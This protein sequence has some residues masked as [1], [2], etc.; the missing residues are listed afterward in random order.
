MNGVRHTLRLTFRISSPASSTLCVALL[1]PSL[2]CPFLHPLSPPAP[3]LSIPACL[4]P[5]LCPLCACPGNST[6]SPL[7]QHSQGLHRPQPQ[8]W[9]RSTPGTPLPSPSP[10]P[11]TLLLSGACPPQQRPLGA[12]WHQPAGPV[13]QGSHR[14]MQ[15]P[16]P[17]GT[18]SGIGASV[19]CPMLPQVYPAPPSRG[20]LPVRP[21]PGTSGEA[22][23]CTRGPRQRRCPGPG[24]CARWLH[25]RSSHAAPRP[26]PAEREKK[27]KRK[28]NRKVGSGDPLIVAWQRAHLAPL[29]WISHQNTSCEASMDPIVL[30]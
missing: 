11:S 27:K 22:P 6:G 4:T 19:G 25:G 10:S 12:R 3:F 1:T 15:C 2:P 7:P 21:A 30:H 26:H 18:A 20:P 29:Q 5:L 9:A 23:G 8:L 24:P 14:G 28:K 17:A 13:G 16:G